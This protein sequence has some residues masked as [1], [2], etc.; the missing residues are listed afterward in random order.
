MTAPVFVVP[1]DDLARL[2]QG[3]RYELGG[4]EG[5]HAAV[6]QRREVGERIDI[7]DGVSGLRAR[8]VVDA[9]AGE[10][11]TLAVAEVVREIEP[12]PKVVLVQA[13]AK[14]DRDDQ[15]VESAAELG[16][17]GIVPWQSA[18][19]IVQ[20][21]GERAEKSRAKWVKVAHAAAKQSRR[22]RVP[23]VR[24]L[25]VTGR[26]GGLAAFVGQ[27]VAGGGMA[28]VLHEEATARLSDVELGPFFEN[29]GG[30]ID[31]VTAKALEV[32]EL[33]VIVGPEGG[34]G[35][36]ELGS[37]T[38]AGATPVLLGQTVLRSSSAGPAAIAILNVRLGRW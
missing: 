1:G 35:Q 11:L 8:T 34:I 20:W 12:S 18:R 7:V 19:S 2:A 32:P 33:L 14:G 29:D 21:K 25:V 9:V 31:G 16:V 30:A 17:D 6:V 26:G 13:L 37:L 23:E 10:V 3:D 15:A 27:V 24:D 28:L 4:A 36:E 5:R 22:S 38:D